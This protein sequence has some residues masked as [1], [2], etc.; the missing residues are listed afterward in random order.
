MSFIKYVIHQYYI[1]FN[2]S[3]NLKNFFFMNKKMKIKNQIFKYYV[4]SLKKI[5]KIIQN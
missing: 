4:F 2:L 1:I 3:N 5:I